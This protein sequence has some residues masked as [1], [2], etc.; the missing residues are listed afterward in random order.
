M[1]KWFVRVAIV[2]VL[3]LAVALPAFAKDKGA[4][5]TPPVEGTLKAVD[6]T[7]NT[8]T[9]TTADGDKVIKTDAATKVRVGKKEATLADLVAGAE[10]KVHCKDG[11]ATSIK[12]EK[13]KK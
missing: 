13:K 10:V 6:A 2:A 4:G 12:V 7:A 1:S 8:V 3:A 5:K 9:V 11:V